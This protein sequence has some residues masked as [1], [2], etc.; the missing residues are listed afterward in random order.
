MSQLV[1][2]LD[3][4]RSALKRWVQLG[5]LKTGASAADLA[6]AKDAS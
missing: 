3:E 5:S 2:R 6:Q 1:P 4:K